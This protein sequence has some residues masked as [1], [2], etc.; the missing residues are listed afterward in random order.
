MFSTFLLS[1]HTNT[2]EYIATYINSSRYYVPFHHVIRSIA[3]GDRRYFDSAKSLIEN[4]FA[5][6]D[7]GFYSHFQKVRILRY[8]R[9]MKNVDSAPG[10]GFVPIERIMASFASIV[11]DESGM[12]RILGSLLQHRL[13]EAA[14]GYRVDGELADSVRITAAG[15]FYETSLVR[16][17]SY[18]DLVCMDTPIKSE[19]AFEEI[20]GT[21]KTGISQAIPDRMARVDAFL[22][23][24]EWDEAREAELVE[25]SGLP[26]SVILPITSVIK[27][28]FAGQKAGIKRGA[29]RAVV[30]RADSPSWRQDLDSQEN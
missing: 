2:D 7:D 25:G 27:R 1:G 5:I 24:L 21:S 30:K 10:R 22:D 23:Y 16:E 3:H 26:S 13:V 18:L 14:N 8:L 29:E 4:L 6:E 15:H 12:R 28:S 19:A 9:E 20:W 11:S 17:F